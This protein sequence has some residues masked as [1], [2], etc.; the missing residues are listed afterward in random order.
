MLYHSLQG[1]GGF[2]SGTSTVSTSYVSNGSS[3]TAGTSFTFSSLNLGTANSTRKIVVFVTAR[4]ATATTVSSVTVAGNS[5]TVIGGNSSSQDYRSAW[6]VDVPSGT[7]GNVVVN[8]A[9]SATRCCVICYALYNSTALYGS[10]F[11]AN[12]S[13]LSIATPS[14]NSVVISCICD[15]GSGH[16]T[17]VTWT[18]LTE[19]IDLNWSTNAQSSSASG[20]FS[21]SGTKTITVSGTPERGVSLCYQ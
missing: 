20:S 12:T 5:A 18:G 10:S 1:A 17:N 6:I 9:A 14:G 3:E 7:S 8:W 15:T 16:Q 2:S 21:T 4:L 11:V 19:D 13:T